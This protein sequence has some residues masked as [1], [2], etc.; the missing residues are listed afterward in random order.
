[1]A[2]IVE[3]GPYLLVAKNYDCF[4]SLNGFNAALLGIAF[5]TSFSPSVQFQFSPSYV[6]FCLGTY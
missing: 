1:M 6:M 3:G 5:W 2:W 4:N